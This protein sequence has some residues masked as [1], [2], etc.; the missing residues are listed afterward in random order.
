MR[1]RCPESTFL[2]AVNL[3]GYKFIYDGY[4]KT[5]RCSVAN[6]VSNPDSVV[7]GGLFEISKDDLDVL[8]KKEGYPKSYNRSIFEVTG[9]SGDKYEAYLYFRIGKN[10]GKPSADYRNIILDGAKDCGL[11]EE[12]IKELEEIGAASN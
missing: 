12:Y 7:W 11:P 10:E 3:A 9:A 8:D 4:S 5:R 2:E 6:I 1:E